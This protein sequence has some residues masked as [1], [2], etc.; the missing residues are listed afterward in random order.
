MQRVL[1]ISI[2]AIAA[3]LPVATIAQTTNGPLTRA[4]VRAQTAEAGQNHTLH[5]SRIGYPDSQQNSSP[6]R[7][8]SATGYG[9]QTGGSSESRM[10]GHVLSYGTDTGLFTHH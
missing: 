6:H 10:P 2:L 3:T 1:C 8:A 5:P 9:T 7:T 4:E